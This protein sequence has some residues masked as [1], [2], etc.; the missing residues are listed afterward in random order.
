MNNEIVV[1][2]IIIIILIKYNELEET[3]INFYQVDK[4][5]EDSNFLLLSL[6]YLQLNRIETNEYIDLKKLNRS[7][8]KY[9]FNKVCLNMQ[10][11]EFK[12]YFR[13]TRSTFEWLCCEII[14]LFR[15]E[16]TESGGIVGLA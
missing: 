6:L 10:D 5:K 11:V 15:R 7:I 4:Q 12:R 3:L 9:W 14:L 2:L 8:S 13:L 16:I 1:L